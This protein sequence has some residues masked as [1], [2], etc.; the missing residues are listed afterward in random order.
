MLVAKVFLNFD[1]NAM[2]GISPERRIGRELLG[3]PI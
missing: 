2:T 1:R 3:Q